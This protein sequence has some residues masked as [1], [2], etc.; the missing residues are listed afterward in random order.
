MCKAGPSSKGGRV[1]HTRK[2]QLGGE[3]MKRSGFF[4]HAVVWPLVEVM[5]QVKL[6]PTAEA[7]LGTVLRELDQAGL[8]TRHDF[9]SIEATQ[10]I[11]HRT[12]VWPL[13]R[14][15]LLSGEATTVYEAIHEAFVFLDSNVEGLHIEPLGIARI[16]DP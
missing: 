5:V 8:T 1:R 6:A 13:A 4:E 15:L 2:D 10:R 12:A 16:R 14:A 11:H 3:K 7:A 9:V